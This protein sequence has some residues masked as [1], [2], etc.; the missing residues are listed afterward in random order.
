M[1]E[2][3]NMPIIATLC[4]R[5]DIIFTM[6][7]S[8]GMLPGMPGGLG[9]LPGLPPLHG[10]PGHALLETYKQQYGDFV[11]HLQG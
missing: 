10:G 2:E 4:G 3:F 1:Q 6:T 5:I 11:K 8:T 9:A 7:F